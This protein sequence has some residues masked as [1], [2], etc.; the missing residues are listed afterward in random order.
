[1]AE[2]K[3]AGHDRAGPGRPWMDLARQP[4][5][6]QRAQM[7]AQLAEIVA[8]G[9]NDPPQ[10]VT[11]LGCGDGALLGMLPSWLTA[12]GYEIGGGDVA[13]G[14]ARGLDIRQADILTQDL[15]YG[16]LL[17]ASEVL[18]HLPD[19]GAFLRGLPDRWLIVSSPSRET[20]NWHNDI[21]SWAWDMPGY[22][23][24]AEGAGWRVVHHTDCPGGSNTFAGVTGRQRFQAIL[25][26]RP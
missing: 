8:R 6:T 3:L 25:A 10:T 17:I 24:L 4:G 21:H 1:M 22:R 19:P 11:D 14:R 5:F 12:W 18:E 13:H 20:G 23:A 9:H 15:E 2:W 16:D 7:V 26:R